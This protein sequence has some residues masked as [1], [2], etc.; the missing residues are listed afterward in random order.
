MGGPTLGASLGIWTCS[1]SLWG[2]QEDAMLCCWCRDV[3]RL[4][5]T[6]LLGLG[7]EFL[8]D[9]GL[10][11]HQLKANKPCSPKSSCAW[12]L[13]LWRL[14][15]LLQGRASPGM[16]RGAQRT[17]EEQRLWGF[18]VLERIR[19]VTVNEERKCPYFGQGRLVPA[20]Q[21]VLGVEPHRWGESA[22]PKC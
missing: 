11:G 16:R 1:V 19:A 6:V 12:G 9:L 21:Q 4:L 7:I 18:S 2:G 17:S 22:L 13:T 5:A 15:P 20:A 8:K 3:Q 10:Q 14:I